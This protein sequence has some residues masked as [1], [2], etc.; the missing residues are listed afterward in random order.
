MEVRDGHHGHPVHLEREAIVAELAETIELQASKLE[1]L[2]E[3]VEGLVSDR[4]QL[5][6]E[7][8]MARA[9]I[10]E[11]AAE[12]Q[13]AAPPPEPGPSTLRERLQAGPA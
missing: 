13:R 5:E 8:H 7:L 3:E 2:N 10:R 1:S 11:L 4:A 6:N 12:L 9:W